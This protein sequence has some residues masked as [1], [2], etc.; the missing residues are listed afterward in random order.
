MPADAHARVT[1]LDLPVRRFGALR[2]L[3]ANVA[4]LSGI[5]RRRAAGPSTRRGIDRGT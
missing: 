5:L 3:W 2:S 1:D 4:A